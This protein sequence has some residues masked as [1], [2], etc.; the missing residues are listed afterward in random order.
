MR[1]ICWEVGRK[2]VGV[3]GHINM[4][5]RVCWGDSEGILA[6]RAAEPIPAR[7]RRVGRHR[8]RKCHRVVEAIH[9]SNIQC[10]DS[11]FTEPDGY[12]GSVEG[13]VETWIRTGMNHARYCTG[14]S[15]RITQTE[16][17]RAGHTRRSNSE[18]E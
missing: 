18:N 17:K 13:K 4:D 10:N 16:G 3:N 7:S 9:F 2:S 1:R 6:E 15:L 14:G 11:V 5:S 8:G 12:R